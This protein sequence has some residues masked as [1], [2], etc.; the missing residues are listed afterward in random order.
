MLSL[1]V[2]TLLLGALTAI[3]RKAGVSRV[4]STAV[5]YRGRPYKLCWRGTSPISPPQARPIPR[6]GERTR[7]A[8]KESKQK[9]QKK[10]FPL[11]LV[12]GPRKERGT[13]VRRHQRR[14]TAR[15]E[16]P[17][18]VFQT[19]IGGDG[20]HEPPKI[21]PSDRKGSRR[22]PHLRLEPHLVP[23]VRHLSAC[24]RPPIKAPCATSADNG[25]PN[26]AV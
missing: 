26:I 7:S 19:Q 22:R 8:T 10:T 25:L 2:S 23:F 3:K 16:N 13:T 24:S 4:F 20:R 14:Q 18:L 9:K 11:P 17:K 1:P 6:S 12:S 21:R 5:R 15:I